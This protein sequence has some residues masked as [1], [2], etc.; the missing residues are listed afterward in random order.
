VTASARREPGIDAL[1]TAAIFAMM[2]AHTTRLIDFEAR[3][4]WSRQ[5]LLFE[6]LIPTL[7]LILVGVSLA[8]SRISAAAKGIA[9]GAWYLR[10][11]RRALGLWL[12]SAVFFALEEGVR[13][14]DVLAASG[15]LCSIAYAIAGVGALLL[16]PKPALGVAIALGATSA[17]YVLLDRAETRAF[18]LMVGNSPLFPLWPLAAAGTLWGLALMRFPRGAPWLAIPFLL[19]AA[20]MAHRHGIDELF[21]KPLGRSDAGRMLAAPLAGGAGKFVPYYSLRPELSL[22]CLFL[23]ASALGATSLLRRFPEF[24]ARVLFVLGRHALEAY[25][26]HL[27][28]LAMLVVGLGLRPLHAAWHGDAVLIG[29]A[30]LCWTWAAA[31]EAGWPRYRRGTQSD[32]AATV[33][34]SKDS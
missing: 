19:A 5:I 4:E 28:F 24:W 12:L 33:S 2:A 21:T 23:H 29:V 1:R 25:V 20:W 9:P 30:L 16:L 3:R 7:F 32:S 8:H 18:L 31:R 17:A 13:F 11:I 10:Q 14:P 6:P 15:I 22:F 27:F 34:V 26:I